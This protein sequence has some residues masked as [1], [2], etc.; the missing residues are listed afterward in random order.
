MRGLN[1]LFDLKKYCY[2]NE[3]KLITTDGEYDDRF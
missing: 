2:N 1:G 3:A